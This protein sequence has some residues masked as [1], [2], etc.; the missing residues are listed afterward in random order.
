MSF[1]VITQKPIHR[2]TFVRRKAGK[3]MGMPPLTGVYN[4]VGNRDFSS[5]GQD[6][7]TMLG[8]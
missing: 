4:P 7:N 2:N 1:G 3:G 5:A 6:R 8:A